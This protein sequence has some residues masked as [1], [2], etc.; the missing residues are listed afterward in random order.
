MDRILEIELNGKCNLRCVMCPQAVGYDGRQITLDDFVNILMLED[1]NY[2]VLTLH[3]AGEVL[4][5][6]IFEDVID[7]VP[8]G[9]EVRFLSNGTMLSDDKIAAILKYH[10]KISVINVSIDSCLVDT[11][12]KI[13]GDDF[14]KVCNNLIKFKR[15][16]ERMGVLTP[17]IILNFTAM[18][19]NLGEIPSV[20]LLAGALDSEVHV[21]PL[22]DA[23]QYLK[24]GWV[25]KRGDYIFSYDDQ[26]IRG[27]L[28]DVY[29]ERVDQGKELAESLEVKLWEHSFYNDCSTELSVRDCGVPKYNSIYYSNGDVKH[30]CLQ[31][32]E[33]FNWMDTP[34]ISLSSHKRHQE[35]IDLMRRDI[36][37]AECHQAGC[38]Y[39]RGHDSDDGYVSHKVGFIEKSKKLPS[40]YIGD[41]KVRK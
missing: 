34:G 21:W 3:G 35:I 8:E 27:H 24:G 20:P 29:K 1:N 23:A 13:R 39:V 17:R 9:K 12:K 4:L 5:S 14:I 18:K 41:Y 36:I 19:E 22:L 30:C 6:P 38:N 7:L 2:D 10:K 11:Y 37:P 15:A 28:L 32:K 16:R 25:V 33:V 26:C 31:T 40:M